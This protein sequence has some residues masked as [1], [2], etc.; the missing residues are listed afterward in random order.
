MDYSVYDVADDWQVADVD[1]TDSQPGY[2]CRVQRT[3]A[4]LNTAKLTAA[5]S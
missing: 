5:P 3:W 4:A 1:K 2:T